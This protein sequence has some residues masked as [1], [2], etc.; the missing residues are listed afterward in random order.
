MSGY[1]IDVELRW[2]GEYAP[3]TQWRLG[4]KDEY[5][6]AV[7]KALP[8]LR[9]DGCP[10]QLR[11]GE[12]PHLFLPNGTPEATAGHVAMLVLS[13]AAGRAHDV[14]LLESLVANA[15]ATWG[16]ERCGAE[17][18]PGVSC[19]QAKAGHDPEFHE[20]RATVVWPVGE[21]EGEGE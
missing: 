16:Q 3:G 7:L 5:V 12:R 21:G 10:V 14:P 11:D 13:V 9:P 17:R 19:R 1:R 8:S 2:G 20:A 18:E 4:A 15:W 6:A